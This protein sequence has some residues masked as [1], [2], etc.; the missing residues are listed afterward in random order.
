MSRVRS[1]GRRFDASLPKSHDDERPGL[2]GTGPGV[3]A[4]NGAHSRKE[5][6]GAV[7]RR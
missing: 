2:S 4:C 3:G 7:G 1:P 6:F 5:R